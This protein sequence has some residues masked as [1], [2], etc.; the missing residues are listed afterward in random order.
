MR[1]VHVLGTATTPFAR[2]PDLSHLD[3][4]RQ[5][6]LA[7]L[8]DAGLDEGSAIGSVHFGNCAMHLFGQPNIRGQVALLPLIREGRFPAQAPIVNVE[9]G[10]ATG[11][12]AFHGAWM[13]VAS[14]HVELAL[15]I[16]VEK[17][18]IPTAPQKMLELFEGGLDQLRPESWRALYAEQAPLCGTTFAPRADRIT[19]LDATALNAAWHMKRYGTSARQLAAVSSKN[20]ANGAKN[21]N[22]QYRTEM[23]VEQVLADKPVIAPFT[24]AMCAPI[25]DGAAA[26]LVCSADFLKRHGGRGRRPVQVAATVLANGTRQRPD[27]ASVT[28]FAATKVYGLARLSPNDVDVAEVHDAT[29]FAEVA[30]T[31][32]LGFCAEGQGGAW[33]ESGASA[34]DGDLP[35]NTSGGLESKGH[36][37]AASGLAMIHEVT[38]QLRG[39]AGARQV[40]GRSVGLAHNAG[41]LIGFDEAMCSVSV[42]R[43]G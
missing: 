5:A 26:V 36:P 7:V 28:K 37:L 23:S 41:G 8:T 3:L 15:A 2:W 4:T 34:L 27:E 12:V 1:D 21:P 39:E 24:R 16:G 13:A 43:G 17:T 18:F 19:I 11:G 20:H 29:A 14:G 9:A 38:L 33:A 40:K 25:S 42:L 6:V 22:A 30:I 32:D 10:C 31:E 35:V